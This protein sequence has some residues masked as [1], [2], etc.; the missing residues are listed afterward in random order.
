MRTSELLSPPRTIREVFQSLPEGTSAQLIENN[1]VMSPAPLDIHQKVLTR[2]SSKMY[3]WVEGQNMGEIRVA[4]YDVFLDDENVLQ[5][6][7]LFISKS[8]IHLIKA[9]GLHGAPDLV[10]EILS[11]STA[12]YDLN[13]KKKLY[14]L[15]GVKEYFIV[16]PVSESVTGFQSVN[17]TFESLEKQKGRIRSTLLGTEFSF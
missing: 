2:L 5:P 3:I 15:H 8:S 17:G 1:L 6:D 4:P 16:D 12:R 7:I 11:P 10:I 14:E 9:D 13:E